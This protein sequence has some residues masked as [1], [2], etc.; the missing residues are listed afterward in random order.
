MQ[1]LQI[2]LAGKQ[3]PETLRCGFVR[4]E[5]A[6]SLVLQKLFWWR[7]SEN[8]VSINLSAV[9]PNPRM[10]SAFAVIYTYRLP[11]AEEVF[12]DEAGFFRKV[13]RK[14]V[15][16]PEGMK[17]EESMFS[18]PAVPASWGHEAFPQAKRTIVHIYTTD[19]FALMLRFCAYQRTL[20]SHPMFRDI[21]ANLHIDEDQWHD[22]PPDCR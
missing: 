19:R 1:S 18:P 16:L 15:R 14:W 8:A 17:F 7:K 4:I 2:H 5:N 10:E 6:R 21:C 11:A 9:D 22:D 20:H 3:L 12:F 13:R